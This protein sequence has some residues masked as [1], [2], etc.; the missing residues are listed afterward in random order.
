MADDRHE[1]Y[2][3]MHNME[4]IDK[5]IADMEDI[6]DI[7]ELIYTVIKYTQKHPDETLQELLKLIREDYG[8]L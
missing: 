3:K 2:C 7:S 4:L 6:I 5:F 8:R 1:A